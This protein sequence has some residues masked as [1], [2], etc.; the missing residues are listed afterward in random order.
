MRVLGQAPQEA[1]RSAAQT[2][3]HRRTGERALVCGH[4]VQ[5]ITHTV[6]VLRVVA[7]PWLNVAKQMPDYKNLHV[8]NGSDS[9]RWC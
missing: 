2:A 5:T 1:A 6:G 8:I 4:S 9:G 3:R 7:N